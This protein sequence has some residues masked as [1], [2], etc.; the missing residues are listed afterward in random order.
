[1][2]PEALREQYEHLVDEVRKHRTAYYQN[3]APEVSDAEY[4]SL[5]RR[6]EDLEA[7]HP[8]IVSNDSPTQE[9]GGEVSTAFAP[10]THL[11]R[12]Y[13]LD[14][15]FS[16]EELRAWHEK[17]SA[18]IEAIAPGSAEK[19]VRWLVEV[20]IDG[21]AVNLLYRDGVLVRAATRGDGTTGEDV[22]HNVMTIQDIPQQLAGSGW[23]AEMEVRGEIFMPSADFRT[24]NEQR[25]AEG[26]APFANPRNSAAGS[27][28][29]KDPAETAKRP[30]SMFVHGIGAHTGLEAESQHATYELLA[31]WGLP[32]SPY[33]RIV[34]SLEGTD[35]ILQFIEDNGAQR[36]GLVHEIDGIVIKVDSFA[37]QRALGHTS[38]VPRWSAAYKYPPEEVHTRL[39]DIRVNVGR[40][41]RVTPYAVMEPVL[42]AGSTVSMATLHNQDVVQA[43]GVLIGDTVVLRKAGDVIPEIVGPVMPLREGKTEVAGSADDGPIGENQVRPFIMPTDC[44]SCGTPLAPAKEGDVDLRCPN[45]RSCPAQLTGRIEHAASRGAFDI[46]ALGEEA[47]LWLTNGPGPD[48]AENGQ[49]VRPEGPGII[50]EDA[51]LFELSD[52]GTKTAEDLKAPFDPA[53]LSEVQARLAEVMVWREKRA[54][55]PETGKLVPS[56]TWELKPYFWTQGTAKKPSEPTANTR[57]LFQE[58]HKAKTQ[59]LW[60]VLVALSIRHVGPTA[61]RSLATAFGSLQALQ[62]LAAEATGTADGGEQADGSMNEARAAAQQRLADVDGVGPIIAEAVIDWFAEPWHRE[63]VERWHAAGVV[64][65]DEQDANTPRTLEGLTIVVT[66]SLEDFSR[67]SAKEA[68]IVRG[69]KA[70][71]S[72]SKKTDY[73]VAGENAGTKLDKAESLGVTVLDE[74]GFRTL[75]A[76][77]PPK[78]EPESEEEPS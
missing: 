7:L 50:T 32:T 24:F 2:P 43:K 55:D 54:K 34:D 45:A 67:D 74:E 56:G 30:L 5:Y 19:G 64:M 69:G 8:E 75:L 36:H 18:S 13:S 37:L 70:S 63:I 65:E 41:G 52:T 72:V 57:R 1:M 21:L 23:P 58:L 40:T 60:R 44:P 33:T 31:S 14:D 49:R 6:L 17:T 10:V 61:A 78:P 66:G 4:D 16:I 59:P 68:I 46:E 51:Q 39:L 26:L 47:A 20:K 28:R 76:E 29:Q 15:L 73:L 9:V 53:E 77:G 12:M 42:V 48:P 25:V 71:G 3:D 62:A 11:A 35:G 27:L 38:R 22:T